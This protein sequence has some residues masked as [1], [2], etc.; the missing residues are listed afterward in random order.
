MA[1]WVATAIRR[2]YPDATIRWAVQDTCADVIDRERLVDGIEPVDRHSW[3]SLR[4]SPA[5]WATQMRLFAGLRKHRFDFGFDLQGHSKTALCLRLSRPTTRASHRSTDAF[6]RTL[7]PQVD[8]GRENVHEIEAH[9]RLVET[10]LPLNLGRTVSMPKVES[11]V[12][13]RPVSIQVGASR[14]EKKYPREMWREVAKMLTHRGYPVVTVGGTRDEA[15]DL[16][17]VEDMVG[18]LSL[19]DTL[20]VVQNSL[21]H[22]CADTGTGHAA[23]AYG[24]PVVSLFGDSQPERYRPFGSDG[25]VLQADDVTEIDPAD[26][27]SSFLFR[28]KGV[29]VS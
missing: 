29:C 28:T 16:P 19:H 1:A 24:V 7:N 27:V 22:L 2:T 10:R 9:H 15:L 14:V 21:A 26:V 6:A 5:L 13:G 8:V 11:P 12:P 23:A 20:G 18:K 17:G 4:W 3:R 25:I